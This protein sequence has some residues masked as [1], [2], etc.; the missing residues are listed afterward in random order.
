MGAKN[1]EAVEWCASRGHGLRRW[2]AGVS[3]VLL[4]SLLLS[5]CGPGDADRAHANKAALDREL[6]HARGDLGLPEPLIADV[7][8]RERKAADGDGGF[9]Y[10]YGAAA[11]TYHQLY[12]RLVGIEQTAQTSLKQQARI[13]LATFATVLKQRRDDGFLQVPIY[14]TRYDD[15]Q[16]AFAQ[17]AIPGDYAH[18]SQ[19]A[20]AQIQALLAMG[21]TY[22]QM[23]ALQELLKTLRDGGIATGMAQAFYD[24]DVQTFRAADSAEGY[25]ALGQTLDAQMAQLAADE[26]TAQPA[27]AVWRLQQFQANIDL[28]RQYGDTA[29][30]DAFQRQHD[31]DAAQLA[32]ATLG[33]DYATLAQT[34]GQQNAATALPIAKAK[35]T[36]DFAILQ[37]LVSSA[38]GKT[39]INPYDHR[40]YP[41]AYEYTSRTVG[42]GDASDNL[43]AAKTVEQYQNV[44]FEITSLTAS[45]KAMLANMDDT[46]PHDQAHQTDLQMLDFYK[47]TSGRAVVVSLREQTARFYQ[48]GKLVNW[49][50]VTTGRPELPSV[51]GWHAAGARLSPTTFTSPDPAGSPNYYQPTHINFAVGY[52]AGGYFLHDA[53]WRHQFGPNTNLPH[54]DPAA[55]NGGTHGCINFPEGNMKWVYNFTVR[56]TPIIVY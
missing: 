15:A 48:D 50:Y 23:Q 39:V 4:L 31:A 42:I 17:A 33:A 18:V 34:L 49:S 2:G 52:N 41:A 16:R 43:K 8:A 37:N 5:A 51:P 1:P 46:T 30:A 20:Q 14:Q 21:I 38:R 27:L 36:S 28:L 54:Y 56:G 53:W 32:S 22:A 45:L 9:F 19:L 25:R 24:Q 26:S 6:T 40:A 7:A 47:I 11:D 29:G 10:N 13:D 12:T 55:F 3:L 35:A 44:D